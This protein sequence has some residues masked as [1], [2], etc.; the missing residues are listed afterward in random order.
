[1]AHVESGD[2]TQL[3]MS[4]WR[5]F[6]HQIVV[7]TPDGQVFEAHAWRADKAMR[8]LNDKLDAAMAR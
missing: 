1:M 3:T 6:R 4:S 5:F 2:I 7:A 8:R